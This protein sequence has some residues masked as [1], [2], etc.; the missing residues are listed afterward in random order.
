MIVFAKSITLGL[1][2]A[3]LF[4]YF[5]LSAIHRR[6]DGESMQTKHMNLLINEYYYGIV[7][8]FLR[9]KRFF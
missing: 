3:K 5:H 8:F 6:M 1:I 2:K 7:I 4:W 9:R